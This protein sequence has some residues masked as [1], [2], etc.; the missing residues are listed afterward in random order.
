MTI[1]ATTTDA[2]TTALRV[3]AS[4]ATSSSSSSSSSRNNVVHADPSQVMEG[5]IIQM[6]D[7]LRTNRTKGLNVSGRSWKV[8]PQKRATSLIKTKVNNQARTW[9]ERSL[10]KVARS[11]ALELQGTLREDRRLSK[12]TKKQR[13][14]ENETRRAEN[15]FKNQQQWAQT[16]NVNKIGSKLKAMS[17]K[18]LR[19]IKKTRL[20]TKTGVVEYVPA[21]AK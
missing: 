10:A 17:K 9:E 11:E 21:Y 5:D 14:L 7:D 13:R 8:R 18:Q 19:Q 12:I 15:Q 20:N 16:L 1:M 6:V 2:T 3:S 4:T